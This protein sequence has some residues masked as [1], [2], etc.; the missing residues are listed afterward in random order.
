MGFFHKYMFAGLKRGHRVKGVEFCR[1]GNQHHIGRFDDLLVA[2]KA[3]ETMVVIN[4]DLLF[5]LRAQPFPFGLDPVHEDVAHRHEPCAGVRGQRLYGRARVASATPDH[6]YSEN[7]ASGSIR[8]CGNAMGTGDG[9]G[10]QYRRSFQ[11]IST[12]RNAACV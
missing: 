6:A 9:G 11:K 10:G 4:S 5:Q 1:I 2:V 8:I 3:R 7:I 12:C